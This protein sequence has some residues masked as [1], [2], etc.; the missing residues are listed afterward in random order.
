MKV[1]FLRLAVCVLLFSSCTLTKRYHHS[2]FNF[3][4]SIGSVK[5]PKKNGL[6]FEL[7]QGDCL[8]R[9]P[10]NENKVDE[11][12]VR[13]EN[14]EIPSNMKLGFL[15]KNSEVVNTNLI[16]RNPKHNSLVELNHG[17]LFTR[18]ID[19]SENENY[20]KKIKENDKVVKGTAFMI[21]VDYLTS[22]ILLSTSGHDKYLTAN[23][24]I[25]VILIMVSLPILIVMIVASGRSDKYRRKLRNNTPKN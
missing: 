13:I 9:T 15:V 22:L 2:G 17:R 18:L 7:K 23:Q 3:Q 5:N 8:K 24:F 19:T 25:A 20:R 10:L 4:L 1:N 21:L 6:Q 16:P 14:L 11:G 12:E